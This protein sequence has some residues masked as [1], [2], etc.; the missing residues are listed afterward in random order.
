LRVIIILLIYITS[1]VSCTAHK[2]PAPTTIPV[3]ISNTATIIVTNVQTVSPSSTNTLVISPTM[4]YTQTNIPAVKTQIA[5]YTQTA[6]VILQMTATVS[7]PP[8]KTNIGVTGYY[9][10]QIRFPFDVETDINDNIYVADFLNRNVL[11][12]SPSGTYLMSLGIGLNEFVNPRRVK[13]DKY[14]NIYVYDDDKI[15]KYSSSGAFL[16]NVADA[17]VQCGGIF[18]VFGDFLYIYNSSGLKICIYNLDGVFVSDLVTPISGD[19]KLNAPFAMDFDTSG[20]I[21][22]ADSDL[23]KKYSSSGVF[24]YSFEACLPFSSYIPTDIAVASNGY[25]YITD[26]NAD[27][28]YKY[29]NSGDIITFWG[30]SGSAN[31]QF[32]TPRGVA[33][34]SSGDVFV[35]DSINGKVKVFG[36]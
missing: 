26:L 16:K 29:T 3:F 36:Y 17:S 4:T 30:T 6:V 33:V 2:S 11:K 14:L 15:K 7:V 21:Y 1:I 24:Q 22:V 8:Y 5:A 32:K 12:Y 28:V 25:I 31:D 10:G 27:L 20:N 13:T 18:D 34:N 23:V 19:G 9:D 35:A